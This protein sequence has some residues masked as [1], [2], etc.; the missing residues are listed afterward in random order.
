VAVGLRLMTKRVG[1]G[2]RVRVGEGEGLGVAVRVGA[3]VGV[4]VGTGVMVGTGVEVTSTEARLMLR[5]SAISC[6][7]ASLPTLPTFL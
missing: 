7:N 1:V 2:N 5:T 3:R 4:L 6:R